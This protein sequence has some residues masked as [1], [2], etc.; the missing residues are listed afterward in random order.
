M[1]SLTIFNVL[2]QPVRNWDLPPLSAARVGVLRWDGLSSTNQRLPSGLYFYRL[3]I[4]TGEA[5]TKKL[6]LVR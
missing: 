3:T 1:H 6:L 4:N 2:G 5:A